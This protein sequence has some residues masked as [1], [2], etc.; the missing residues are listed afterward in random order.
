MTKM[1]SRYIRIKRGL[2]G[3]KTRG[4]AG[5]GWPLCEQTERG[6]YCWEWPLSCSGLE[7]AQDNKD[8]EQHMKITHTNSQTLYHGTYHG[9]ALLP[10]HLVVLIC[11]LAPQDKH[12]LLHH[13]EAGEDHGG[14]GDVEQ[15]DPAHLCQLGLDRHTSEAMWHQIGRKHYKELCF[16]LVM[17][18]RD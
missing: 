10:P 6:G 11:R 16:S 8:D 14:R 5:A 3:D 1:L 2:G 15:R 13:T 4:F 7:M 12:E 18:E 17:I 9:T